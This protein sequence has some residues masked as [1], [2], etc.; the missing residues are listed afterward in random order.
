MKQVT[1]R[2][3]S[4]LLVLTML[5]SVIPAV[6]AET[7]SGAAIYDL[8]VEDLDSPIGLD[9][10]N[11]VFSWKMKS[12]VLGAAQTAYAITVTD[13]ENVLWNTGW[14]ES[15]LSVGI[16]YAGKALQSSVRYTVSVPS[17]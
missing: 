15:D 11:P 14:V 8:R 1:K 12:D 7:S 4:M 16:A 3:I 17:C 6:A 9:N 13:G 2:L 10:P 5:L